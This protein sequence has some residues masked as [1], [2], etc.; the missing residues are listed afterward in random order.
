[1]SDTDNC[2]SFESILFIT[3]NIFKPRISHCV[4]LWKMQ[5]ASSDVLELR[6][7]VT[8]KPNTVLAPGLLQKMS[9]KSVTVREYFR[10]FL[11]VFYAK[12]IAK[13]NSPGVNTVPNNPKK[14]PEIMF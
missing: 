4:S 10:V 11:G 9:T 7:F 14:A 13:C 3:D 12:E 6:Y 8:L 5:H 2:V 1:M